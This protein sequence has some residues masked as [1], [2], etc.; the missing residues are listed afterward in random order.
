MND[1]MNKVKWDANGLVLAVV[2]DA[3]SKEVLMCAYMNRESLEYTL[4]EKKCCYYSRS[5]KKLWLKG[6]TSGHFQK[7]KE[8]RFD[9]DV[10]ALLFLVEQQGGAC[11]EGYESC[12][13]RALEGDQIRTVGKKCFDPE[14]VYKK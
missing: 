1:F 10:D 2:Q 8:V 5:R 4:K 13:Y 6:E 12:F 3:H 14:G 11:H 9:C 7:V